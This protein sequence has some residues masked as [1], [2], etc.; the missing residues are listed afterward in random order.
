MKK[1]EIVGVGG[2]SSCGMHALG[3][4]MFGALALESGNVLTGEGEVITTPHMAIEKK[5]GY[6][7]KDRDVESLCLSASIKDNI[8]IA[9]MEQFA[10]GGH[11][12]TNANEKKY[13]RKQIQ[14]LSIKCS[15]GKSADWTVVRRK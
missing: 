15:D 4:A 6:V 2:L 12:I 11:L 10:V 1:G 8:A 13:V 5:I 9:G 14:D 7:S 3:K